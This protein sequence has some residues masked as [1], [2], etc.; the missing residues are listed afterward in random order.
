MGTKLIVKGLFISIATFIL[1]L[2]RPMPCRRTVSISEDY[3][4]K[5]D[6]RIILGCYTKCL[7]LKSGRVSKVCFI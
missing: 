1:G 4:E 2:F 7:M 5:S 3:L 6:R